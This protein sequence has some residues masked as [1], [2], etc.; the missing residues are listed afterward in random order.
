MNAITDSMFIPGVYVYMR[1]ILPLFQLYVGRNGPV[2]DIRH[3]ENYDRTINISNVF[4]VRPTHVRHV[5]NVVR[6]AHWLGLHVRA[7]GYFQ[8]RA[9]LYVDEGHVML[10][11]TGL[12]RHDGPKLQI[13]EPVIS[14]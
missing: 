7:V 13:N 11:I 1:Q 6:A 9:P 3:F 8:S 2:I 12:E 5:Q 14:L 10:D 4:Y